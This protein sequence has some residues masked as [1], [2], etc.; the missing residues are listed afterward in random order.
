[1]M[2]KI[3]HIPNK[4][5][6]SFFCKYSQITHKLNRKKHLFESNLKFYSSHNAHNIYSS[7]VA[8]LKI[9]LNMIEKQIL[10]RKSEINEILIR[11]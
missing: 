10:D 11:V 8:L 4:V 1:M 9:A 6:F 5:Y 7:Q 2:K 3:L